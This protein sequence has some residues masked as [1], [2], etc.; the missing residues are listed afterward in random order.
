MVIDQVEDKT[1]LEEQMSPVKD[2]S[3]GNELDEGMFHP[4]GYIHIDIFSYY[5]FS[6]LMIFYQF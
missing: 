1:S 4:S 3:M 6:E 2:S 5:A